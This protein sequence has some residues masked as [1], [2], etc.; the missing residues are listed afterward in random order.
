MARSITN[1]SQYQL[2]KQFYATNAPTTIEASSN[3]LFQSN[4]K[5]LQ[6]NGEFCMGNAQMK[7]L[8]YWDFHQDG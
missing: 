1:T 4:F 5:M 2:S 8:D 6:A 7:F 3:S